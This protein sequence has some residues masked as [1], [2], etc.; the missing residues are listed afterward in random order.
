MQVAYLGPSGTYSHH[1][2]LSYFGNMATEQHHLADRRN[3]GGGGGG[4]GG[5]DDDAIRMGGSQSTQ[6][7]L[8]VGTIPFGVSNLRGAALSLCEVPDRNNPR[9]AAVLP[10]CWR[11]RWTHITRLTV[12]AIAQFSSSTTIEASDSSRLL[13]AMSALY[14][15]WSL[16]TKP[17]LGCAAMM[18]TVLPHCHTTIVSTTC[19]LTSFVW[20]P[21]VPGNRWCRSRTRTQGS[22]QRPAIC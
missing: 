3:G 1:A 16:Q 6:D 2:V 17:N 22:R 8:K 10:G 21:R 11:S 20:I 15:R 4:G 9:A 7:L 12:P 18:C 5:G 13:A 19:L 14:F